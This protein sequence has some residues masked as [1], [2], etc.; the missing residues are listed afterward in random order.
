MAELL[1]VNAGVERFAPIAPKDWAAIPEALR[2]NLLGFTGQTMWEGAEAALGLDA[3]GFVNKA[4]C[5]LE[6]HSPEIQR[7][8]ALTWESATGALETYTFAQ[9]NEH[10]NCVANGLQSLGV[11]KGDRVFVFLERIPELYWTILGILKL[12]AIAGPLFAAFG[13]DAVQD[14]LSDSGAVAIVTSPVL[15][16]RVDGV[17]DELPNLKHVIVVDHRST[18]GWQRQPGDVSYAECIANQSHVFKTVHTTADDGSVM[19]YTSGTTGK[20]KGA[21]HRHG[22]IL[23]QWA[24]AK[25]VLDLKPE[26]D[27][28]WCTAD[29]GWVT[30]TAYGMF[31]PWSMGVHQLVTEA[32]FNASHWYRLIQDHGVTVWYTAP[33]AIRMLM[34]AGEALP[35]QYDLSSLRHLCSVGEPLNPEAI[36]WGQKALGHAFHDT[37]WQTETGCMHVVNTPTMAIKPGSMGKPIVGIVVGI[38]NEQWEPVPEGEEGHLALRPSAPSL[39]K[40]YWNREEVYQS[41]F[42]NGW[43]LTGDRAWQ[44]ADGYVWFVGR[45][46]DVINTAGHLVGPFEVES[47]LVEHPAVA[48]AA[49]IGK[50]CPE[51]LEVVKAFVS[52]K[53]EY[54][55]ENDEAKTKLLND[56][57]Q[58]VRH[59]LAA[60]AMPR[61]ISLVDSIPK[62]RSGK[63]MRR[64][65]KAR[66]LGLPEGDLSTLEE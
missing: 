53:T 20:P 12:G 38:L 41:K 29:P 7:R 34:K 49:V 37:W 18:T 9:L 6:A 44:D 8:T 51:R 54:L 50:P 32:P 46:D 28:Y 22:A 60:H 45:D 63:I 23:S 36:V 16:A 24:T 19:H 14:R 59:R 65:L 2:P 10:A 33:T 35:V 31:G 55:P 5:A 27:V 30:G 39:F 43:Y 48:E 42:Q 52:L 62:T 57:Q 58:F 26:T 3:A 47:A 40:T 64:L 13:P 21:L 66:E 11:T 17:R 4:W 15:K 25:Y 1:D 61:E 56:I